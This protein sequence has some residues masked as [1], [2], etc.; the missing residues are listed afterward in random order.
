M[1]RIERGVLQSDADRQP[2]GGRVVDDVVP[3]DES[4][5]RG[6]REQG[7]ENPHRR[8][9]AGAVRP[10]KAVDLARGDLHVDTV[11]GRDVAETARELLHEDGGFRHT[12][13]CTGGH[14]SRPGRLLGL[15]RADEGETA[16]DPRPQL[17]ILGDR[18]GLDEDPA[19]HRATGEVHRAGA[20]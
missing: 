8:R 9:L 11:D 12:H 17:V 18:A 15:E 13:E 3:G 5:A 16:I 2:H 1:R 20:G 14:R 10:E 19:L 7:C 4:P 6:G